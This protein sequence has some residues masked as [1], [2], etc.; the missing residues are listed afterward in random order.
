MK[1][2]VL[3]APF[4][5]KDFLA[6]DKQ[7]TRLTRVSVSGFVFFSMNSNPLSLSVA[8]IIRQEED[9]KELR[10][11]FTELVFDSSFLPLPTISNI[12][13]MDFLAFLAA[14]NEPWKVYFYASGQKSSPEVHICYITLTFDNK[15][16]FQFYFKIIFL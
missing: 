2:E 11:E 4:A 16:T 10:V 6:N 5:Q 13:A 1:S 9:R 7:S 8:S 14:F 12:L 3:E 15:R